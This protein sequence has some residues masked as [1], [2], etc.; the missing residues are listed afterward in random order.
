MNFDGI[1]ATSQQVIVTVGLKV[2]GAIALWI[3]GRWLIGLVM[4]LVERG[5]SAKQFDSTLQRYLV[6]ILSVVLTV[7]LVIGI[8]GFFGIETTSFA[9][10]IA[11]AG[12]A[13]GAAWSGLLANFA[14]GVFLVILRP[15]KVGDYVAGGGV[16]G[17]V[18][19][20]GLF[21]TTILT[22]D[23]VVTMVGNNKIL[24]DNVKNFSASD[25]RRV[26]RTAQIDHS[27]DPMDA[28]RLLKARL[29]SIPNV[30]D[31]PAPEVEILALNGFGTELAVRPHCRNEHYW[32]VYFD[33]NKAIREEF[34]KANYP[35]PSQHETQLELAVAR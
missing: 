29:P 31:K 11:A 8:L 12:I 5:L 24:S 32:Q 2:L 17:T 22:P 13:I 18:R 28:I 21:T 35:V 23:N 20:V 19:E 1:L 25:F 30:L 10:L 4:R 27:V 3:V 7:I 33:T 26:D 14:A 6:S 16:E 9:A 34:S 15:F